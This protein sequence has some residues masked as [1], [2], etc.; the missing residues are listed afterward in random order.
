M[1]SRVVAVFSSG[2]Q[3]TSAKAMSA[4]STTTTHARSRS[5]ISAERRDRAGR[6]AEHH[7][8]EQLGLA[9]AEAPEAPRRLGS[10]LEIDAGVVLG[11]DEDHAPVLSVRNR[12]LV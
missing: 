11:D 10:A 12:F 2:W 5:L 4:S 8:F 7:G 3:L 1:A 9:E 6:H